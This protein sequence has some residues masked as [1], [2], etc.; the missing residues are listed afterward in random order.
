M[1]VSLQRV[2]V[3][4]IQTTPS[5]SALLQARQSKAVNTTPGETRS[6]DG[7]FSAIMTTRFDLAQGLYP[8]LYIE[9][10][11]QA[12]MKIN[13]MRNPPSSEVRG[14]DRVIGYEPS[15]SSGSSDRLHPLLCIY[16]SERIVGLL[17][18]CTSAPTLARPNS[19]LLTLVS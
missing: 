1:R 3:Y 15:I 12:H 6:P 13:S 7:L 16:W 11:L 10:P 2:G 9:P 14:P 5:T 18:R 4:S 17:S 19:S 8:I